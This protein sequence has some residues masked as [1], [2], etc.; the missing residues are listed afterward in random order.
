MVVQD[1]G[2]ANGCRK[3]KCERTEAALHK[4]GADARQLTSIL[5]LV[6]AEAQTRVFPVHHSQNSRYRAHALYQAALYEHMRSMA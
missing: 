6:V 3:A 1:P 4:A 2:K 5:Y